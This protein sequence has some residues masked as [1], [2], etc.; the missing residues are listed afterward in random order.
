M[1]DI[2]DAD[3]LG[4]L[5]NSI[6]PTS[7]RAAEIIERQQAALDRLLTCGNHIALYRTE[8]WPDYRLDGLTRT[9]QCESALRVMGAGRDYDMW[10]CW[11]GMMQ[12]RDALNIHYQDAETAIPALQQGEE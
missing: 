3:V 9:Q 6:N 4:W 11:S 7:L 5:R 2:T 12:E 10:C 1:T 8:I